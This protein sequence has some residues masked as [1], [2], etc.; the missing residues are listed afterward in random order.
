MA[1]LLMAKGD[2]ADIDLLV[3]TIVQKVKVKRLTPRIALESLDGVSV[4]LLA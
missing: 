1:D 2:E 4:F 3:R